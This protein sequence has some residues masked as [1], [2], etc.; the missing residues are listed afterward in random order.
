MLTSETASSEDVMQC[1]HSNCEQDRQRLIFDRRH[2]NLE[3]NQIVWLN[4][5]NSN[6]EAVIEKF[7]AIA[8]YVKKFY[9]IADCRDYLEQTRGTTTIL[10]CSEQFSESLIPQVHHLKHIWSIY[11]QKYGDGTVQQRSDEK[12]C[13]YH[14]KV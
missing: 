6:D 12:C 2:V 1:D 13:S 4:E 11:I 3:S 9:N 7:R 8:D 14:K 10:I 5:T